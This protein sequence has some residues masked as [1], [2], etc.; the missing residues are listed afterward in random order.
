MKDPQPRY[1]RKSTMGQKVV[2]DKESWKIMRDTGKDN[3]KTFSA[4]CAVPAENVI[5]SCPLGIFSLLVSQLVSFSYINLNV[6]T[7]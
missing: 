2:L 5:E 4:V 1:Q 3:G 7:H 6:K